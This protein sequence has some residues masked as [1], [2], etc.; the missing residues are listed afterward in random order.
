[1]GAKPTDSTLC[2]LRQLKYVENIMFDDRNPYTE[3]YT[4]EVTEAAHSDIEVILL[5]LL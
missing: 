2:L 3:T 1:M 4:D 5:D